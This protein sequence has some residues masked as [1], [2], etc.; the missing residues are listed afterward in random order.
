MKL[1]EH[2]LRRVIRN[3]IHETFFRGRWI[4]TPSSGTPRQSSNVDIVGWPTGVTRVLD[5]IEDYPFEINQIDCS[6]SRENVIAFELSNRGV[7]VGAVM[8][9]KSDNPYSKEKWD[10][11]AMWPEQIENS[12]SNGWNIERVY[13]SGCSDNNGVWISHFSNL[14][15]LLQKWA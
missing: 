8:V 15:K 10:I 3:S 6:N 9:K 13:R 12:E 7:R 1:T 14:P 4:G 2:Q 5:T 11:W